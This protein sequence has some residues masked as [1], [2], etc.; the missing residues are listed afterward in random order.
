[1]N[2]RGCARRR[3][4]GCIL[5]SSVGDVVVDTAGCG[6]VNSREWVHLDHEGCSSRS[7]DSQCHGGIW[8]DARSGTDPSTPLEL[9]GVLATSVAVGSAKPPS[10]PCGGTVDV[11]PSAA[12]R[13]SVWRGF[14]GGFALGTC[15]LS[16]VTSN[17]WSLRSSPAA[18]GFGALSGVVGAGFGVAISSASLETWRS[19]T[20]A[21]PLPGYCFARQGSSWWSPSLAKRLHRC[22]I[23]CSWTSLSCSWVWRL[24]VVS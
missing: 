16:R 19:P 3:V 22:R 5:G 7:G 12:S 23:C 11:F 18:P 2:W 10:A 14:A 9:V 21:T 15:M 1:M 8:A 6:G 24:L 20:S 13:A 17:C 4:D